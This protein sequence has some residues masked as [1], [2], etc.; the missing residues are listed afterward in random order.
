MSNS[1]ILFFM[2]PKQKVICVYDD[3]TL[4]EVLETMKATRFSAIPVL[5]RE[6]KY[7]GTLSEGDI[8]WYIKGIKGFNFEDTDKINIKDIP[9]LRDNDPVDSDCNIE[10]LISRSAN[11]NFVPVLDE[12]KQFIGIITRKEVINYF[13]DHKFVVL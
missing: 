12:E 1:K 11:E 9:R 3:F 10:V 13:F 4:K 7:V 2:I 8:L 5:S 6:G